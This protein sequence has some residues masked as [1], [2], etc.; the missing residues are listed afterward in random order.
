MLFAAASNNPQFMRP[1]IANRF[2]T[3]DS[4]VSLT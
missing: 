4:V 2:S 3:L 1:V